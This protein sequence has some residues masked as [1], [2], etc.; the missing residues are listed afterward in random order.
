MAWHQKEPFFRSLLLFFVR[1]RELFA[2]IYGK[3][4]KKCLKMVAFLTYLR[5]TC[6]RS[7]KETGDFRTNKG[8]M[9]MRM[10]PEAFHTWSQRLQLSSKTEAL[11]A[12]IRSSPPVRRVSGRANNITGRYPSPKMGVSIQ[13]ESDH[14]EFWAIYGMERDDDVLEFYDQPCRIPLSY[15]A[16]SG[17]R[18]THWHTPAFLVLRSETAGWEE[19]KQERALDPLAESQPARYQLAG[20]GQWYCPPGE[21]YA[22]QFGLTY[23]LRSS[24]E[25]HPLEIQHLKFLQHFWAPEFLPTPKQESLECDHIR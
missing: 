10:T 11:I 14:V 24:A 17:R 6:Y 1:P 3:C 7:G 4:A 9:A 16:K 19:W 12:S 21:A 2:K 18:T 20:T 5:Y 13:F 8:K 15:R 25:F 23:R 22:E